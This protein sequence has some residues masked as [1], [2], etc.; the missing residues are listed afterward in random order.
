[1]SKVV[2][3]IVEEVLTVTRAKT[4]WTANYFPAIPFTA[5]DF[6]LGSLL[7]A[8]LYMARW[9]HRRGKG[10]FAETFGQ[11]DASDKLIAP[12]LEDVADGLLAKTGF[13]FD[14]FADDCGRAML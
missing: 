9:G 1:M 3:T 12:T 7:P 13:G 4:L 5:Q 14:G 8:M 2:K 11:R 6:E 10:N